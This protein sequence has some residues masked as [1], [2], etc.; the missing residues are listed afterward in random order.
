RAAKIVR[1]LL[2]FAGSR[3]SARRSVSV[4]AVLQKALAT[5]A[6]ACRA[7]GI[8]VVRH[9]DDK[10]PR[11]RSDALL[12]HQVFLNVI[13]N[14]EHAI[15]AAGRDGTIE[16]TTAVESSRERVCVKVR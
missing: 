13:I 1:N 15:A 12:L 9:Y 16:V 7:S 4:N 14:A 8:E 3:R 2:V 6:A 11:V 5:R 10:L